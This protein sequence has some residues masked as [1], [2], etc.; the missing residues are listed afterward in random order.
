MNRKSKR[1]K[2]IGAATWDTFASWV[3]A[4]ARRSWQITLYPYL[5][6]TQKNLGYAAKHRDS[7]RNMAMRL[8]LSGFFLRN[9][10]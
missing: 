1:L 9:S 7:H 3:A 2:L 5:C 10:G 8:A 4:M 6:S